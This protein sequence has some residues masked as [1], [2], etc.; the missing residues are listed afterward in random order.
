MTTGIIIQARLNSSRFPRKVMREINGKKLIDIV[1]DE[2]KRTGYQ[3]I[4]ATPDTELVRYLGGRTCTHHGSENDV[5]SRFYHCA[6]AYG[7]DTIVRVTADAK[8]IRSE[9]IQQQI[10]N[11]SKYGDIVYGNLLEE[12]SFSMLEHYYLHDKRLAT[13]EHV[14]L[15][16]LQDMSVDWEIDLI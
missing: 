1:V 3:V 13:R 12:L 16:M 5:I 15:G 7:L 11:H 14:T 8:N 2:C 9:L 6:K 10:D 4:V